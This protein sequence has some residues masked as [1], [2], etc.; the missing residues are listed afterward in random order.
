[1]LTKL[2]K[3]TKCVF[4]E[5]ISFA[6][7]GFAFGFFLAFFNWQILATICNATICLILLGTVSAA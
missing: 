1:M 5:F 3:F 4:V 7:I 6:R 2:A